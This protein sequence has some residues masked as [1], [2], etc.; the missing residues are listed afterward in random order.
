MSRLSA[1]SERVRARRLPAPA[2]AGIA[3][4]LLLLLGLSVV[5]LRSGADDPVP[6]AVGTDPAVGEGVAPAGGDGASPAPA[7][8]GGGSSAEG[9]APSEGG[10]VEGVAGGVALPPGTCINDD[11]RAADVA[12]VAV[13]DCA[14]AHTGEVHAATTVTGGEGAPYPGQGVLQADSQAFCQGRT[15][16]EYIG[17][18]YADSRLFVYW[19]VPTEESWAV[20]DRDVA[21]I[22][23]DTRGLMTGSQ[24][25]TRQ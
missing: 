24:R 15:F 5:A 11:G 17:R 20:G 9:G 16:E 23:Y 18:P 4:V 12:G 13:V 1:L 7:E 19:L 22:F 10:P 21:C 6:G 3:V 14:T 25:G 8:T 2:L